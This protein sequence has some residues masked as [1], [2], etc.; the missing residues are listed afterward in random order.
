MNVDRKLQVTPVWLLLLL[1]GLPYERALADSL[2]AESVKDAYYLFEPVVLKVTLRLD[3]PFVR[4]GNDPGEASRQARRL[5]CKLIAELRDV[6]GPVSEAM[7]GGGSFDTCEDLGTRFE[8]RTIG[9]FGE[10]MREQDE[11]VFRFWHTPGK[12]IVVVVDRDH[13][14]V[15]NDIPITIIAPEGNGIPAAELFQSGGLPTLPA[16]H[17]LEYGE[18]VQAVFERLANE[19]SDTVYGKY[20]KIG[21]LL[22][23]IEQRR[24]DGIRAEPEALRDLATELRQAVT[25]F[26]AGHPLRSR[27]LYYLAGVQRAPGVAGNP[28]QTIRQLLSETSDGQMTGMAR[29]LL[30]DII[31]QKQAKGQAVP[32]TPLD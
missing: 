18:R 22:R 13:G 2:S 20:A 8:A 19:Y 21:L 7:L 10:I 17:G 31:R 6:R 3:E 16:L 27:A 9:V 23:R 30:N 32:T 15:S 26:E 4:V 25:L 28:Q 1:G 11:M 14:M 5:R 12:Y 29:Q 24:V